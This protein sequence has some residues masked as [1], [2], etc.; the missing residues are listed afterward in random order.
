[1]K[2]TKHSFVPEMKD[3][4]PSL[5]GSLNGLSSQIERVRLQTAIFKTDGASFV[6]PGTN[7]RLSNVDNE[8]GRWATSDCEIVGDGLY[9]RTFSADF[10]PKQHVD[11]NIGDDVV[12]IKRATLSKC[13]RTDRKYHTDFRFLSV[14]LDLHSPD[15]DTK[16][17]MAFTVA[18]DLPTND[19]NQPIENIST[20]FSAEDAADIVNQLNATISSSK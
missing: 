8:I 15:E 18:I 14:T 10:T 9:T 17:K 1:M 4:D 3:V 16:D 7:D 2:E 20:D 5:L 13:I 11:V 19:K 12:S 6:H